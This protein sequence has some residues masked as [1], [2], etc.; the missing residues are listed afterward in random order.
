MKQ[1]TTNQSTNKKLNQDINQPIILVK[2][3]HLAQNIDEL[4]HAMFLLDEYCKETGTVNRKIPEVFNILRG[5][6]DNFNSYI[7]RG[8]S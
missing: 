6:R 5:I 7:E 1:T 8:K 4:L 3:L 2:H